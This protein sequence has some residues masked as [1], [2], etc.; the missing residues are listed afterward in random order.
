MQT[1]I[2][3][4]EW[5]AME[6]RRGELREEEKKVI[7]GGEARNEKEK[8]SKKFDLIRKNFEKEKNVEENSKK[9]L[10]IKTG[11]RKKIESH[12]NLRKTR[13]WDKI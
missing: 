10:E 2:N 1:K 6:R 8:I 3:L 13:L 5:T 7:L 4:K 9:E 11:I 12:E